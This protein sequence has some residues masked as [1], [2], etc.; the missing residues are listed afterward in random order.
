MIT[1]LID[2]L[3]DC[4]PIHAAWSAA[5]ADAKPGPPTAT[6]LKRY[7]QA[8]APGAAASIAAPPVPTVSE[9]GTPWELTKNVGRVITMRGWNLTESI[10]SAKLWGAK[11]QA[12]NM[13]TD[14]NCRA[15]G[16]GYKLH[17]VLKKIT[18]GL[19]GAPKV[20]VTVKGTGEVLDLPLDAAHLYAQFVVKGGVVPVDARTMWPLEAM[21]DA[22]FVMVFIY[23]PAL[24]G[25][26]HL[27][28]SPFTPSGA[29]KWKPVRAEEK[30]ALT[31][32]ARAAPDP[33]GWLEAM[34]GPFMD[35]HGG[36]PQVSAKTNGSAE[37]P[38]ARPRIVVALSLATLRERADFEPGGLVGMAKIFPNIMVCSAIPLASVEGSVKIERTPSTTELDQG[39]GKVHGTCCG[40]Y[41]EV[42]ALLVADGNEISNF[43]GQPTQ[44]PFWGGTFA[45]VEV[46]ANKRL[47]GQRLRM[48]DRT[49]VGPR[50]YAGGKRLLVTREPHLTKA[51][52]KS[53]VGMGNQVL[54]GVEKVPGQGEFD[55]LHLAPALKLDLAKAEVPIYAGEGGYIP[56]MEYKVDPATAHAD[57]VWMAPFCA[58]DCF[59][60]HVRW[61]SKESAKWTKGWDRTGPH[62]ESGA[63]MVPVYQDVW[64]QLLGP[65][66]YMYTGKST[67]GPGHAY[68]IGSWDIIMHHGAAYA[69]A[70]SDWVT[71]AKSQL[72]L[73]LSQGAILYD[74]KG[75]QLTL[76]QAP[77]M[78]WLLRYQVDFEGDK[79]VATERLQFTQ[80]EVDA[81][82]KL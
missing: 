44:K 36:T 56:P 51:F 11:L 55:N 42:G 17:G 58:H 75:K 54:T 74:S 49:K 62:K 30:T 2:L 81:A 14:V 38:V 43:L 45:Y 24:E 76:D 5:A 64:L 26:T 52:L 61:G 60:T 9:Y 20:R 39:D 69:Q 28:L 71:F 50:K 19:E 53:L 13:V 21:H 73:S 29:G 40:A 59:H 47:G 27:P 33:D 48:V 15:R 46:A 16:S 82:R 72:N 63:P 57:K 32:Q 31:L 35:V 65:S 80:G 41:N 25:T 77:L 3:R 18:F 67:F 7:L 4:L 78:Y 6:T 1:S 22:G 23:E 34:T 10:L 70:I 68:H 79:L 8:Q 37:A 66:S 12:P